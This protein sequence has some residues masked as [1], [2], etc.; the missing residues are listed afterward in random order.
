MT[1]DDIAA[2]RPDLMSRLFVLLTMH[3]EDAAALATEGQARGVS[4]SQATA[5]AGEIAGHADAIQTIAAAAS[6]IASY[7]SSERRGRRGG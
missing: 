5:L 2:D 1:S 3:A 7:P 6:I 4:P